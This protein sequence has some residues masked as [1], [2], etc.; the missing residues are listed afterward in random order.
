MS[1]SGDGRLL[2]VGAPGES[3]AATG[4]GGDGLSDAA[5]HSGAA[6]LFGNGGGG[7]AQQ[8]YFKASNTGTEDEFGRGLALS[9]DGRTFAVGAWYE[10]SASRGVNGDGASDGARDN[11]A[12]Y[13]FGL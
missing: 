3:S 12:A 10:D 9:G 7:W 8:G 11:G 2:A 6:Y 4:F 5:P 13:V 1:L